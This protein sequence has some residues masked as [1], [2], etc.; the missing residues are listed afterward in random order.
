MQ[1]TPMSHAAGGCQLSS[2]PPP[3]P[4]LA[5][6]LIF[7]AGTAGPTAQTINS[8]TTAS[9]GQNFTAAGVTFLSCVDE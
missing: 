6:L 1:S 9:P 4:A 8:V 3:L 5:V 2:L 7:D